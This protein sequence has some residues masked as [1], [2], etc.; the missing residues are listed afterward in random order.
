MKTFDVFRISVWMSSVFLFQRYLLSCFSWHTCE[1]VCV[2]KGS[3]IR[4]NDSVSIASIPAPVVHESF[5]FFLC[6]PKVVLN[7]HTIYFIYCWSTKGTYE[8]LKFN[9]IFSVDL[10][11]SNWEK[12]EPWRQK[13]L[14]RCPFT[15]ATSSGLLVSQRIAHQCRFALLHL[16]LKMC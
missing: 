6:W 15:S 2:L 7:I 5:A 12:A 3:D 10:L 11:L 8:F 14:R 1:N 9:V 4:Y 16:F 13:V